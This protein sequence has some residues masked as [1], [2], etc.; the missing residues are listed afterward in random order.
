MSKNVESLKDAILAEVAADV[1]AIK[2]DVSE[3]APLV[4][5]LR[6]QLPDHFDLLRSGLIETLENID[7][8]IQEAARDRTE[9]AKGQL[10]AYIETAL[11]E[12]LA[13]HSEKIDALVLQFEKQ[14]TVAVKALKSQFSEVSSS[15]EGLKKLSEDTKFPKWAKI[16]LPIVVAVIVACTGIAT[17]QFASYKEA[18]YMNAF[19]EMAVTKS[20][21]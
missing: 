3:V 1:L 11:Q 13:N 9:F 12:S 18:V 16:T 7:Q 19:K 21:K 6:A 17:W 8:A 20:R 5:Q 2:Q 15:M 10:S 4:A 14:N